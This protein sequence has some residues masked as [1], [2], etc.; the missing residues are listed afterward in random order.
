[1]RVRLGGG[2]AV[3]FHLLAAGAGAEPRVTHDCDVLDRV[4]ELAVGRLLEAAGRAAREQRISNGWL[5][6]EASMFSWLLPPGWTGRL[7]TLGRFGKLHV[8]VLARRDLMLMK[9]WGASKRP[10]DLENFLALRPDAEERAFRSAQPD[11]MEVES[12]D[13][14]PLTRERSVLDALGVEGG[15]AS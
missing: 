4:P 3:R 5:N 13:R 1:M 6:R 14:E 10:A 7:V 12:L 8:E 11:R 2:I 15:A 9:L